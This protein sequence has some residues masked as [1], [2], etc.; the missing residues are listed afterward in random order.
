LLSRRRRVVGLHRRA[1]P[2]GTACRVL[3]PG[4]R[5]STER[6]PM[7]RHVRTLSR[8][9]RWLI[10]ATLGLATL[11]TPIAIAQTSND[12]RPLAGGARNPAAD[13][14]QSFTKET[15]I[16]ADNATYGTRQSNKSNNGGGAIYG[17]RSGLGGTEKGNEPCLRANN[18]QDGRAFEFASSGKNAAEVGRIEALNTSA[19]PLTTNATGVATGFNADKVDGKDASAIVADAQAQNRFAIVTEAG[20]LSA[21]RDGDGATRTATGTYNVTFKSDISKCAYQATESTIDDSGAASVA[22]AS[23]TTIQVRTRDADG[24]AANRPFH[25]TVIC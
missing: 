17:C 11:V 19:A 7:L 15:E 10:A 24:T 16:I 23:A 8:T 1:A 13:Q 18:L 20:S 14:R 3:D 21:S 4:E 9:S 22:P 6:N 2:V 5:I 25:L 12:G